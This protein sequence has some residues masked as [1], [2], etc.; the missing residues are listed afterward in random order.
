MEFKD[1][2]EL[3]EDSKDIKLYW[4][5]K[6]Y[7]EYLNKWWTYMKESNPHLEAHV[8]WESIYKGRF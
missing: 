5:Q 4:Y 3:L 1:F 6:L 2:I 7:I 8:L